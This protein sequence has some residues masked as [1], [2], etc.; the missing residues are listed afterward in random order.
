M[1]KRSKGQFC[2]I[3]RL[4]GDNK[5]SAPGK[6]FIQDLGD[7]KVLASH[8]ELQGL[9]YIREQDVSWTVDSSGATELDFGLIGAAFKELVPEGLVI[10]KGYRLNFEARC[11]LVPISKPDDPACY[12]T[13]GSFFVKFALKGGRLVLTHKEYDPAEDSIDKHIKECPIN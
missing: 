10:P 3:Y 12:G 2:E 5:T 6:T 11:Y 7:G 8:A 13:A 1:V 4:Q 9:A